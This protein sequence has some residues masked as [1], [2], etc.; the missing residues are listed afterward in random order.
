MKFFAGIIPPQDIADSILAIQRPYGDNRLEP[1]ITLRPPV[2]PA[3]TN[4][5]LSAV[6]NIAANYQPFQ[7]Q[8]SGTG[9]FGKGVLFISIESAP[10]HELHTALVPALELFEPTSTAHKF[11]QYHPHMTL[12]RAWCGFT[13]DAFRQMQALADDYMASG[14]I[15]FEATHIRI[16]QKPDDQGRFQPYRD[17]PLGRV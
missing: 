2:T 4:K 1:H 6:T 10:L 7:I 14:S 16:Y 3:D 15:T 9:R 8:L 11:E 12:G 13:P 5:W 17:I